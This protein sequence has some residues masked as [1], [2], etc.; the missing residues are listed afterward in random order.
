MLGKT[1][2][3]PSFRRPSLVERRVMPKGLRLKK[4]PAEQVERDIRRARRAAKKATHRQYR[5]Y[6]ADLD[7]G[8]RSSK[9]SRT[10][11]DEGIDLEPPFLDPGL[12]TPHYNA[13]IPVEEES[14]QEKLWD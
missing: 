3:K 14:F 12:S 7:S 4:T 9:R 13:R 2:R 11:K 8:G 6:D 1:G 5:A 10:V